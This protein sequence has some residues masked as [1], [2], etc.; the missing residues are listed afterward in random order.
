MPFSDV[1]SLPVQ[2]DG[3]PHK[4]RNFPTVLADGRHRVRDKCNSLSTFRSEGGTDCNR[5]DV[6]SVG[7][8]TGKESLIGQRS[9]DNAGRAPFHRRHR[10]IGDA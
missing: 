6:K 1:K 2:R 8:K 7:N 4:T 5:V 9:A 10:I 3:A